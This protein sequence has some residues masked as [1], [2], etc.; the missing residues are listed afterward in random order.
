MTRTTK[1]IDDF[2]DS[3]LFGMCTCILELIV[4][5]RF[6][7]GAL[8]LGHIIRFV[9]CTIVPCMRIYELHV[10][11]HARLREREPPSILTG[12]RCMSKV[13]NDME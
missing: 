6:K 3:F 13:K 11:M 1:V 9:W 10:M 5:S 12:Y 4:G 8:A 2:Y 7:M